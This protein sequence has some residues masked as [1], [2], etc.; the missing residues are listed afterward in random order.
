M[1][2]LQNATSGLTKLKASGF[3]DV[4]RGL[5]HILLPL[6]HRFSY[7]SLVAIWGTALQLPSTAMAARLQLLSPL[8]FLHLH[9]PPLYLC[10]LFSLLQVVRQGA[11]AEGIGLLGC[12]V[13]AIFLIEIRELA[14]PPSSHFSGMGF[15][16]GL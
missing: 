15:C 13:G 1:I 4:E 12:L 3:A 2:F 11:A 9:V 5:R 7:H 16:I 6:P 8:L 10:I 14:A